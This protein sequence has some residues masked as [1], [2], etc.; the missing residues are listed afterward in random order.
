MRTLLWLSLA[1]TLVACG[2][3]DAPPPPPTPPETPPEA[4]P[5]P[6]P[7]P[8]P[9]TPT[10]TPSAEAT[11]E[12]FV[13]LTLDGVE[14][15]FEYLPAAR[16]RA[17]TRI[18][19]ME[20]RVGPNSTEQVKLLLVGIDARALEYPT[21]I[22]RDA[23]AAARGNLRAAMRI[24]SIQY[25]DAQGTRYN[26]AFGDTLECQSLEGLRLRCTFEAE[27]HSRDQLVHITNGQLDI[28]LTGDAGTDAMIDRLGGSAADRAIEA[29]Q[30]AVDRHHRRSNT[31]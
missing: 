26:H 27:A 16:N 9:P 25:I 30:E 22:A 29:A 31:P 19:T 11:T 8:D 10:P 24:P 21:T 20:A 14:R 13:S 1:L 6:P 12:G 18:T 7:V 28:T 5:E 4:P 17:T 23:D 3:S 15:R 2:E